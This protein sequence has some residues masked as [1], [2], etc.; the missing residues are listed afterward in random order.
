MSLLR[1][2]FSEIPH[3]FKFNIQTPPQGAQ[4][5]QDVASAYFFHL[6]LFPTPATPQTSQTESLR[7]PRTLL[8]IGVCK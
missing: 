7:I 2:D 5:L 1:L 4:D 8:F 3:C 6:S